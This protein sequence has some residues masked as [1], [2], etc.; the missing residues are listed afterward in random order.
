MKKTIKGAKVRET[1][2]AVLLNV[3]CTNSNGHKCFNADKWFPKSA[4]TLISDD[5]YIVADWLANR[6]DL[7]EKISVAYSIID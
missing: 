1:E 2:K 6:I 4:L 7:S 3:P 5:N